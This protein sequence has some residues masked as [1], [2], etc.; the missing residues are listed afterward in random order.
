METHRGCRWFIAFAAFILSVQAWAFPC[1]LTLVKDS[2]WTN[3]E[4]NV[5]MMDALNRNKLTTITVPKSK[6]W[7]RQKFT[8]QPGQKLVY[9]ATFKP[10]FWKSEVGKVYEATRFWFLPNTVGTGET[11]WDIPVCFPAAFSQVPFPPDA[12]G[13]CQCDFKAV[14][15]IKP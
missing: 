8:C 1:Y 2:C 11:A 4:V 15:S 6:S 9:E 3:Y 7:A 13:N 5:V 10:V 14:P 12:M